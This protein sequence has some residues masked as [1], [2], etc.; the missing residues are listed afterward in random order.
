MGAV[1]TPLLAP[2]CTATVRCGDSLHHSVCACIVRAHGV[3]CAA[4]LSSQEQ[5]LV[6]HEVH[7]R[8]VLRTCAS[9]FFFKQRHDNRQF[10]TLRA[11]PSLPGPRDQPTA[12]RR[13]T[14][15]SRAQQMHDELPQGVAFALTSAPPQSSNRKRS[16]LTRPAPL[17]RPVSGYGSG[18][19][20]SVEKSEPEYGVHTVARH[21]QHH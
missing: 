21:T 6:L 13:T 15:G 3:F 14:R 16:S 9:L 20:T 1:H 2:R 7:L 18:S 4:T 12:V 19:V 11:C 5:V 8:L 10:A 17:L